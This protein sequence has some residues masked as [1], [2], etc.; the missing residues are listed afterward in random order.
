MN[1][2][3]IEWTTNSI[4]T[5]RYHKELNQC[6]LDT[7]DITNLDQIVDFPTR[8]ANILEIMATNRPSLINKCSPHIGLSDHGTSVCSILTVI[9]IRVSQSILTV[10]LI[11]VS[12]SIL[13]VILI[14]VSQSILTVILIRVSQ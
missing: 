6:F 10:I 14:R 11:R 7:F 1:L 9:L 3:D 12:Q 2:P 8:G 5:H 4:K 13:T